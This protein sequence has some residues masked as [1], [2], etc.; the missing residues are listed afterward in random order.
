MRMEENYIGKNIFRDE[1]II[2]I[3]DV[4]LLIVW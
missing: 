4:L 2:A 3:I 1:V